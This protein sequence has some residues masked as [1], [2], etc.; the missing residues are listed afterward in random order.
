M[1]NRI[2][3]DSICTSDSINLLSDKAEILFYRLLVQCDDHGLFDGRISV[4]RARCFP[5]RVDAVK[6][7]DVDK[8]LGEL[9]AAEIVV[10]YQSGGKPYIAMKSWTDHQQVRATHSKYPIPSA[11][12][13][14]GY[15][16]IS[17]DIRCTRES[18][19][20]ES[21]YESES[22]ST[23]SF[24]L[25]WTA[26]P[27][28]VGKAAAFKVWQKA[29][30]NQGLLELILRAIEKQKR[31]KQWT[32]QNGQFIP[33]PATWL[34]QGRWDDELP[35]AETKGGRWDKYDTTGTYE[36]VQDD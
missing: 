6:D 2:L 7:K 1:P 13:I 29:K 9:V 30:A 3:K 31:S 14:N 26:Y 34:T 8:W 18:N 20:I 35:A 36:A 16:P 17:D 10:P 24:D 12:D 4:I 28:K 32:E 25:F 33:N 11:D 22:I 15:Q 23:E 27:K 19:R 21:E 5:L